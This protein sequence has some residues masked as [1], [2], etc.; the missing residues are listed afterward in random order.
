MSSMSVV[1]EFDKMA[2]ASKDHERKMLHGILHAVSQPIREY[3]LSDFVRWWLPIFAG[4]AKCSDDAIRQFEST[5]TRVAGSRTESVM[6]IDNKGN[7]VIAVPSLLSSDVMPLDLERVG[8]KVDAHQNQMVDMAVTGGYSE[9]RA[10]A[11]AMYLSSVYGLGTLDTNPVRAKQAKLWGE[12]VEN[13]IRISGY[14]R[15]V[16]P[17]QANVEEPKPK[18]PVVDEDDGMGL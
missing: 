18:K 10:A 9:K 7:G 11:D 13:V 12:F 3:P 14:K 1:E 16:N 4:D 5:W 17:V 8:D 2:K 15:K 6:L